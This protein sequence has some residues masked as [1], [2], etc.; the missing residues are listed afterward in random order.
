MSAYAAS[1]HSE[2][3]RAIMERIALAYVEV[4]PTVVGEVLAVPAL[5]WSDWAAVACVE[6]LRDLDAAAEDINLISLRNALA[7]RE[8]ADAWDFVYAQDYIQRQTNVVSFKESIHRIKEYARKREWHLAGGKMRE[9]SQLDLS[10]DEV[11]RRCLALLPC[12]KEVKKQASHKPRALDDVLTEYATQLAER[13]RDKGRITTPW[14]RLN[15]ITR[16]LGPSNLVILGARTSIGKTAAACQLIEWVATKHGDVLLISL[17]MDDLEIA[18][19]IV[20]QV[21]RKRK[22]DHS[23]SDANACKGK[24]VDIF[25]GGRSLELFAKR[26]RSYVQEHPNLAMIVVDQLGNLKPKHWPGS[27][28]AEIGEVTRTLKDIAKLYNV[29]LV[30]LHQINRKAESREDGR[31]TLGDLK[32]SGNVEE[33]ADI[34]ILLHR[35]NRKATEGWA[36]VEKNRD[37]ETGD[38]QLE[39]AGDILTYQSVLKS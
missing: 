18:R 31:P 6:S 33:D 12:S 20:T 23:A 3:A 25:D 28:A 2:S 10:A 24:P 1:S 7:S 21:S 32:D 13:K 17:E 29:P 22:E 16:G 36:L 39:W 30:A 38:V 37:G 35:K 26:V 4:D 8:R 9:I 34:V 11:E 14:P 19:R 15:R 5:A 27:R